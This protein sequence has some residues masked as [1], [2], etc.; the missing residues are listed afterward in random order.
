M[1]LKMGAI[2]RCSIWLRPFNNQVR[3]KG[4]RM[5]I[6][7]NGKHGVSRTCLDDSFIIRHLAFIIRTFII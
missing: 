1:N 5:K 4:R 3:G 6:R 2:S 7:M